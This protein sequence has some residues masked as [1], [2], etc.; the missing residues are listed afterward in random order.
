MRI[1]KT[2]IQ[3]TA[4]LFIVGVVA[5]YAGGL[6]LWPPSP[7]PTSVTSSEAMTPRR[8]TTEEI[9]R[10]CER[11][12][13]F[14]A[15]R[16]NS[17]TGFLVQPGM[18]ATNAH[19]L[20]E[21][22]IEEVRVTFPAAQVGSL[23]VELL[24]EDPQRDLALLAVW[25]DLPP[26][27]VE[28]AYRFRRGQDVTVIGNPGVGGKLILKN[29]V[30]RG[31]MSTEAVIE[32]QS[33]YQLNIA[34]NHGNS[35]GPA[36]DSA[37]KVLGVVTAKANGLESTAFCIPCGDLLSAIAQVSLQTDDR[38]AV[39]AMHR[40]RYVATYLEA[41]GEV[42]GQTLSDAVSGMDLA[43]AN[44]LDPNVAIAMVRQDM[45]GLLRKVET[46]LSKEFD[47][48][49][50]LAFT[51]VRIA[52][53]VRSELNKVVMNCSEMKKVI[54][55]PAGTYDGFRARVSL[56]KEKHRWYIE[57]LRAELALHK[58]K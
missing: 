36:I 48:E 13:A 26:L 12:V 9:A 5:T 32:S 55:A 14:V 46:F 56:L 41:T 54:D 6:M 28:S 17:G 49:F 15:G 52:D 44:R 39:L 51:D 37:G 25:T 42:Y 16:R 40:M 4:S 38:A 43:L 11:A 10:Q 27:E 34:I 8:F 23:S 20:A 30:S 33:Y 18:L 31:V 2:S 1:E 57:R 3:G 19:V 29:A 21:E 7:Q 50:Q 53:S 35:G 47:K 58:L 45:S 22:R 24:F